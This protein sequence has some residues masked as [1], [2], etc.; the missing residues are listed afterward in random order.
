M[1]E[2]GFLKVL[3]HFMAQVSFYTFQ[4][5]QCFQ[6]VLKGISGMIWVNPLNANSTKWSN[7][8]HQFFG[9]MPT[10]CLS[11]FDHFVGL[12][13]KG[14]MCCCETGFSLLQTVLSSSESFSRVFIFVFDIFWL[15]HIFL[16]NLTFL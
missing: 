9:K 4:V 5:F 8:F 14:L 6:G 2:T 10:S 1:F 16:E 15:L 13:L 3:T 7:T 12:A 11:M